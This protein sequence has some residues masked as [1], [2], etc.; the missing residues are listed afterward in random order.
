VAE[1]QTGAEP[2]RGTLDMKAG[3]GAQ[4]A[5]KAHSEPARQNS[6]ADIL[7]EA[8]T[9]GERRRRLVDPVEVIGVR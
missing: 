3:A 6:G 7:G 9:I 4:F 8:E 5:D 1:T 2:E